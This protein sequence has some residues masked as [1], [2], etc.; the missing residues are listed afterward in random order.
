MSLLENAHAVAALGTL[1]KIDSTSPAE[2]RLTPDRAQ[3]VRHAVERGSVDLNLD[4]AALAA[5]AMSEE[6]VEDL[7]RIWESAAADYEGNHPYQKL[8]LRVETA[9]PEQAPE[10]VEIVSRAA[11]AGAVTL[12][13]RTLVGPP[14]WD[15]PLNIGAFGAEAQSVVTSYWHA[16]LIEFDFTDTARTAFDLLI[17]ESLAEVEG[18]RDK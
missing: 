3:D 9:A 16:Q 7:Q 18:V 13:D 2:L 12:V 5:L 14:R 8:R 6:G 1:C 17:F 10:I 11:N 4:L 15:L